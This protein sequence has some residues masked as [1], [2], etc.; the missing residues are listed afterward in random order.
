MG[1]S[2]AFYISPYV[3]PLFDSAWLGFLVLSC[4]LFLAN[5]SIFLCV[6]FQREGCQEITEKAIK[7]IIQNGQDNWETLKTR[8]I[9]EYK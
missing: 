1:P 9:K 2:V 5:T 8:A 4:I 3:S 6:E 7:T